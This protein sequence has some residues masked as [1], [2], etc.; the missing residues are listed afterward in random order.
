MH[1]IAKH[2]PTCGSR[3]LKVVRTDFRAKIQGKRVI[4][5]ALERQECPKCGEIL[6]DSEAMGRLEALRQKARGLSAPV[7]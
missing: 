3:K 6:F 7:R 1:P 4:V 5:P 2:C